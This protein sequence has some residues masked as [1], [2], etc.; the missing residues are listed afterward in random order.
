MTVRP[1][2]GRKTA[3]RQRAYPREVG[4]ILPLAAKREIRHAQSRYPEEA[5]A[6]SSRWCPRDRAHGGGDCDSDEGNGKRESSG[7]GWPS[8][9]TAETW[10]STRPDYP[11]GAPSAYHPNMARGESPT[12][13]EIRSHYRTPQ[14]GRRDGVRKLPRH[15]ARVT[16]GQGSP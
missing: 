9:G 14:K 6:A 5:A 1:R 11:A 16:R 3:A 13:V 7:A 8:R 4:A 12:V 15:L 2:R 10:T